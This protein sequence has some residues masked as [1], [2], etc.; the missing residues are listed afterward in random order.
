MENSDIL[1]KLI[2]AMIKIREELV[3][4]IIGPPINIEVN[5]K[6]SLSESIEKLRLALAYRAR[7]QSLLSVRNILEAILVESVPKSKV[8]EVL[9]IVNDQIDFAKLNELYLN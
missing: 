5:P 7:I 6:E 2:S 1:D 3:E 4:T 9:K 8:T